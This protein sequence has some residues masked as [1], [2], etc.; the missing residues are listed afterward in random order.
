MWY[1]AAWRDIIGC[2]ARLF[3]FV[4]FHIKHSIRIL[5]HHVKWY[6]ILPPL[7]VPCHITATIPTCK[8]SQ[9]PKPKSQANAAAKTKTEI[10]IETESDATEAKSATEQESQTEAKAKAEYQINAEVDSKAATEAKS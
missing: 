5:P 9:K 10:D 2:Y 4:W 3:E 6:H 7:T 1:N 8:P